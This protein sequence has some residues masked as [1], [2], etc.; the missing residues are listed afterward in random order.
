MTRTP[1]DLTI[2][3]RQPEFGRNERFARWWLGGDPIGTAFYNALSVTFP[4]GER[5]FIDSVRH[6]RDRA[7]ARLKEQIAAFTAQESMHSRE[8]IAFN[9]QVTD[10]G[11]D[12]SG[13]EA[14]EARLI[15]MDKRAPHAVQLAATAALEHFTAILAHALL[16]NPRHLAGA[17]PEAARLWRWHAM[18]EIEHKAVAFD[19]FITTVRGGPVGRYLL[20]CLIMLTATV[21]FNIE[22]GWNIADFFRQDGLNRPK[23]WLKLLRFLYVSPGLMRG[24]L[25]AYL[26]YYRPGFHPWQVDDRHLLAGVQAELGAA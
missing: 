10:N 3:P 17:S 11:Y 2:Q 19:T 20:R 26:S 23:S 12:I 25:G 1:D 16:S 13:M 7:P 6:Y 21:T 15:E 5:F 8:H 22:I 9:R 4:Q 14:R 18:E 24:V